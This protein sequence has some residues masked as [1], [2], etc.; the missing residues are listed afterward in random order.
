M[1][2]AVVKKTQKYGRQS[3]REKIPLSIVQTWCFE[4]FIWADVK[5]NASSIIFFFTWCV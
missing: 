1:I 2:L 4:Q 5:M 3:K